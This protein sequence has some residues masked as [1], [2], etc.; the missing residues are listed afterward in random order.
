MVSVDWADGVGLTGISV[1]WGTEVAAI[2]CVGVEAT[3]AMAVGGATGV[4]AMVATVGRDAVGGAG[5]PQ[6]IMTAAESTLTV[7]R[8]SVMCAIIVSRSLYCL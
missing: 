1:G 4:E 2:D 5:V 3:A 6:P 7:I 8:M